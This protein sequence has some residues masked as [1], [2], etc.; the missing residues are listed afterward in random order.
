M[1]ID[2]SNRRLAHLVGMSSHDLRIQLGLLM[3]EHRAAT[4]AGLGDNGAYMTELEDELVAAR[5]AYV[6]LAV[7]EI[8]TFRG[9]LG[10]RQ[11]G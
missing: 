9:Q 10:G 3:A 6:G 11:Q 4:A 8:A 7:T 1:P 2:V 5:A